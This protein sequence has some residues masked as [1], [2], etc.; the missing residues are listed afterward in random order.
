GKEPKALAESELV[1]LIA[2]DL[3]HTLSHQADGQPLT[4]L[5]PPEITS[6]LHYYAGLR[7]LGTF[8]WENRDGLTAAAR[9]ASAT[10]PEEAQQ[11]VELRGVTH[12]VMPAW[13]R[14]LDDYAGLGR[15]GRTEA[16]A[17]QNSFV[18]AIHRWEQPGWLWPRAYEIP[19]IAGFEG[20]RV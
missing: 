16:A 8:A 5:A 17:A 19:A 18:A 7:G 13:D 12:I 4:V 11:L 20:Q 9:M 2:R 15:A 3:A 6:A 1:G 14:F 10:S